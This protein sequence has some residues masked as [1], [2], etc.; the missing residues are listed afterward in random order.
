MTCRGGHFKIQLPDGCWL[1][2]PLGYKHCDS[3]GESVPAEKLKEAS[4][5]E[6]GTTVPDGE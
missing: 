5:P 4:G 3:G 6:L 1:Y 2:S